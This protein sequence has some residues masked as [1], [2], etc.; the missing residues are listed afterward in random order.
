[1]LAN[2]VWSGMTTD[3][4][5]FRTVVACTGNFPRAILFSFGVEVIF[6]EYTNAEIKIGWGNRKDHGK[7]ILKIFPIMI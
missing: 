6:A 7:Y 4:R 2:T 1:M 5:L 3:V